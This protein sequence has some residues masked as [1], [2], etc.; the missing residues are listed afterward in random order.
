MKS[1]VNTCGLDR[2][3]RLAVA[4]GLIYIAFINTQIISNDIIRY[5]IGAYVILNLYTILSGYCP[6][7]ALANISTRRD[8]KQS[9]N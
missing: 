9:G 5:L 4:T 7:Y 6:V 8:C 2:S 1:K 3:I